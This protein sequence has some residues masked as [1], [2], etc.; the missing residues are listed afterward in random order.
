MRHKCLNI[1]KCQRNE[2]CLECSYSSMGFTCFPHTEY[3]KVNTGKLCKQKC[4]QIE[5][6]AVYFLLIRFLDRMHKHSRLIV[7]V[8]QHCE[9]VYLVGNRL[10]N[11]Q[12]KMNVAVFFPEIVS[13][14]F[15]CNVI[16]VYCRRSPKCAC[17]DHQ[18]E[19]V[20][21]NRHCGL[22]ML[23]CDRN[24]MEYD[25]WHVYNCRDMCCWFGKTCVEN[26]QNTFAL[27][28]IF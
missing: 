26:F 13:S 2:T 6:F 4:R 24:L 8:S 3:Y 15:L 10:M 25:M 9:Y 23:A 18:T 14:G 7:M 22:W 5:M 16:V 12:M 20:S 21:E 11:L 19:Y 17:V 27:T 1:R 28:I